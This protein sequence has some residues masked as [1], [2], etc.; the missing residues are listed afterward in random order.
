MT[1]LQKNPHLLLP[2]R[3]RL[4]QLTKT[5]HELECTFSTDTGQID[6]DE[7]LKLKAS[8]DEQMWHVSNYVEKI[9]KG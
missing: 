5:V 9:K 7:M 8:I 1:S 3:V 2:L 4:S 6:L